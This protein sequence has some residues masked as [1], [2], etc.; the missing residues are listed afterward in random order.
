[1]SES[2]DLQSHLSGRP[3][4][5]TSFVVTG[6][7]T[8]VLGPVLPWLTARWS[9]SDAAAGALF[10]IQFTGSIV[11]G[12]L[13]GLIV[14]RIGSSATLSTGYALMAAGLAGLALGERVTGTLA[15]GVA[16]VGLGF[17]VPTTNLLVA[18]LT[19]DRA[20]ASLGAL[21]LCWGI[22]AATWPVI[23]ARFNPT[24]GVRVALVLVSA[25]LLAVAA[26]M[27]SAHFP[28]HALHEA[29]SSVPGAWSWRRLTIFGL[30]IAIY[31]GVEAAFGGWIAEYT[32]RLT[33]D[34]STTMRWETAA[35]AFWGGLAGGRGLV[36]AGL[37]RRFENVAIFSGLVLVGAAIAML[38][39]VS[40]PSPVF[41]VAVACGLGLA[42][43]FPV[44]MA[45]LSRE[46]PPKVAQPMIALGSVGAATVPWLVGAI[47]SRTGSLSSGLSALLALLAALVVLH[48]LRVKQIAT[49]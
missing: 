19:P 33:V 24:P 12:A 2:S 36:A 46:V 37:A 3:L 44:T 21:N 1:M 43:S 28:V 16:G 47:S 15:I 32:R 45:A 40:G 48:V 49:T 8:T 22:G 29:A 10:T 31:S 9:L 35:S 17:V 5:F 4:L 38:L 25:L 14:A 26:R 11:A 42:P 41:A 18:R 39:V 20:A 7:V 23:V 27:T 34:V 30:C 6:F 13:S